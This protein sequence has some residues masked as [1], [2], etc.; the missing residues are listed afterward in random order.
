MRGDMVRHAASGESWHDVCHA[1]ARYAWARVRALARRYRAEG[2]RVLDTRGLSPGPE[3]H[4]I[5]ARV[6]VR[7]SISCLL[8]DIGHP[9]AVASPRPQPKIRYLSTNNSVMD[10]LFMKRT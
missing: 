6:V 3:S 9:W 1:H 2:C 10:W 5:N 7:T 8:T 4:S